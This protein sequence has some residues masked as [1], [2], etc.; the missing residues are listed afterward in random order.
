MLSTD[1]MAENG[2]FSFRLENNR[3]HIE[4]RIH[5]NLYV[6]IRRIDT[7]VAQLYFV[8]R[9]KKNIPIPPGISV[10]NLSTNIDVHLF[11]GTETFA[12]AWSDSYSVTF[13]TDLIVQM[14]SQRQWSLSTRFISVDDSVHKNE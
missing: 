1:I 7:T 10:R 12:L 3:P 13:N 8:D 4:K 5:D 9:E 2:S 6:R 14:V 11:T